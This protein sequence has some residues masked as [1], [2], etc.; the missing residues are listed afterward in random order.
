V[1][2][3]IKQDHDHKDMSKKPWRGLQGIKYVSYRVESLP[4]AVLVLSISY[5]HNLTTENL[6]RLFKS[7]MKYNLGTLSPH[8]RLI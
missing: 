8:P 5:A 6:R 1:I 4:S 2:G 3:G 7:T